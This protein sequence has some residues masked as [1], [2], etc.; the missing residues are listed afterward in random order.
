M[1]N[2]A[3]RLRQPWRWLPFP[4][5]L[6][7]ARL[8][9]LL[10]RHRIARR[11]ILLVAAIVTTGVL[12][13]TLVRADEAIDRWGVTRQVLVATEDLAVGEGVDDA[14]FD[15]RQWPVAVVPADAVSDAPVSGDTIVSPVLSGEVLTERHLAT[16]QTATVIVPEGRRAI[17]IPVSAGPLPLR[18]GDEVDVVLV[19]DP[20]DG[21]R[22]D[23]TVGG[24]VL[25]VDDETITVAVEVGDLS[26]V[27]QT[28]LSGRV[29]VAL[30]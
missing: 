21:R 28:L 3:R 17:G 16:S 11:L 6:R 19:A 10:V 2:V 7:W 9:A 1:S 4:I 30:R 27:A 15:L 23:G 25:L 29:A 18:P 14:T 20:L 13:T 12:A 8:R 5:R 24:L 22:S 26:V